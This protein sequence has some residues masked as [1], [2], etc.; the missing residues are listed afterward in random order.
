[1]FHPAKLINNVIGDLGSQPTLHYFGYAI[2]VITSKTERAEQHTGNHEAAAHHLCHQNK[3]GKDEG[4]YP[5]LRLAVIGASPP[6]IFMYSL[7]L[8][9][10]KFTYNL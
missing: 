3:T 2:P 7:A 6:N 9:R 10:K 8:A 5:D 1:M 4:A